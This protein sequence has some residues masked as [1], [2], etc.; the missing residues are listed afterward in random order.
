MQIEQARQWRLVEERFPAESGLTIAVS[1][2]LRS[3]VLCAGLASAYA[4]AFHAL[5]TS[6]PYPFYVALAGVFAANIVAINFSREANMI[7]PFWSDHV[8]WACT[9]GLLVLFVALPAQHRLYDPLL[10]IC[11]ALMLS[12]PLPGYLLSALTL[13]KTATVRQLQRYLASLPASDRGR[14]AEVLLRR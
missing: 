6:F 11:L 7:N 9:V 2:A 1:L 10:F 8:Y 4:L 12:L 14:V 3:V 5:P 13:Q